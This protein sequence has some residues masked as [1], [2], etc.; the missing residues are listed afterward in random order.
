MTDLRIIPL[1]SRLRALAETFD[2]KVR[3]AAHYYGLEAGALVEKHTTKNLTYTVPIFLGGRRIGE[4]SHVQYKGTGRAKGQ[5]SAYTVTRIGGVGS[6]GVSGIMLGWLKEADT[7]RRKPKL[8]VVTAKDV[9]GA[10]LA[11]STSPRK[12]P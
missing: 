7:K 3:Y 5:T 1:D 8:R 9:I 12:K 2:G 6:H 11:K 4:V 10:A